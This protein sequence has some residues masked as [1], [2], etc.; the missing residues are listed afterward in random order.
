M[1]IKKL[2]ILVLSMVFSFSCI[3]AVFASTNNEEYIRFH[4]NSDT[5][6]DSDGYFDFTIRSRQRSDKFTA[7]SD[8]ITIRIGAQIWDTSSQDYVKT[9][10]TIT[11]TLYTSLGIKVGSFTINCDGYDKSKTFKVT[12]GKKYY[13][14]VSADQSFSDRENLHIIGMGRVSPI[15]L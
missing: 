11:V 2:V 3:S 9:S 14:E 1:K 8:E 4:S 12:D 15:S 13:F 10:D 6:M 5:R 7:N